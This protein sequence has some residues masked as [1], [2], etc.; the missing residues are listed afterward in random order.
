MLQNLST[1]VGNILASTPGNSVDKGI[2]D[3]FNNLFDGN[4]WGNFILMMIS[5]F[6]TRF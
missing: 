1:S 2:I 3:Y 4:G 6:T 5:L